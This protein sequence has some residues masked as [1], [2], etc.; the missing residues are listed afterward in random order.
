MSRKPTLRGRATPTLM[1]RGKTVT[2]STSKRGGVSKGFGVAPPEDWSAETEADVSTPVDNKSARTMGRFIVMKKSDSEISLERRHMMSRQDLLTGWEEEPEIISPT[3]GRIALELA[4]QSKEDATSILEASSPEQ[5]QHPRRQNKRRPRRITGVV[6]RV[7]TAPYSEDMYRVHAALA[8]DS[9]EIKNNKMMKKTRKS[10]KSQYS[11]PATTDNSNSDNASRTNYRDID[12]TVIKYQ[13]SRIATP[14]LDQCE[15]YSTMGDSNAF[16]RSSPTS[17]MDDQTS[18]KSKVDAPHTN[19]SINKNRKVR[20]Y[21]SFNY[22]ERIN[23]EPRT[24][25]SDMPPSLKGYYA[26][27]STSQSTRTSL[28]GQSPRYEGGVNGRAATADTTTSSGSPRLTEYQKR[29]KIRNEILQ[30]RKLKKENLQRQRRSKTWGVHPNDFKLAAA[31]SPYSRPNVLSSPRRTI[32]LYEEVV[33][34]EIDGTLKEGL[35]GTTVAVDED[36]LKAVNNKDDINGSLVKRRQ[37]QQTKQSLGYAGQLYR[38]ALVPPLSRWHPEK[39]SLLVGNHLDKDRKE[40]ALRL[41]TQKPKVPN[42]FGAKRGMIGNPRTFSQR[43]HTRMHNNDHRLSG[44]ETRL[45][46]SIGTA[47]P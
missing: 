47:S 7:S 38:G 14:N 20:K 44:G 3:F 19:Q 33:K 25:L 21:S 29:M 43:Q 11:R 26:R 22:S 30:S 5:F 17:L 37:R 39:P 40:I 8:I 2:S 35:T 4:G 6:S 23:D 28:H 32:Y 16:M 18:Y 24:R 41:R 12:R 10:R 45:S 1:Y 36:Q 46:L 9:R 27:S 42:G 15:K 34:P 13:E 31:S